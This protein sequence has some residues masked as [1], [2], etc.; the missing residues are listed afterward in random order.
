M[1]DAFVVVALIAGNGQ[2]L[3]VITNDCNGK[4]N[5][6][7]FV[8]V[9]VVNTDGNTVNVVVNV[10]MRYMMLVF[11]ESKKYNEHDAVVVNAA[12]GFITAI[13]DIVRNPRDVSDQFDILTV[14]MLLTFVVPSTVAPVRLTKFNNMYVLLYW[15]L[16]IV[17]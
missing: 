17:E 15:I 9:I 6:N 10:C 3:V 7:E 5:L 12:F 2:V 11:V 16:R 8:A 1:Y 4:P 14:I 13:V